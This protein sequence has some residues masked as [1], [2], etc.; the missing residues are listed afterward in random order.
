MKPGSIQNWVFPVNRL[1]VSRFPPQPRTTDLKPSTVAF[2]VHAFIE[3]KRLFVQVAEKMERLHGD[4]RSLQRPLQQAL[5]VLHAIRVNVAF[6]V[7][8]GVIDNLMDEFWIQS[9]IRFQGVRESSAP[10]STCAL[11]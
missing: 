10:G 3:P 4:I 5:K 11:T 9:L 1:Y 2:H 6:D 7:L 8:Y